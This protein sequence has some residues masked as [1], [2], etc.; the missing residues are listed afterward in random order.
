M[1]DFSQFVPAH[2]RSLGG[3]TPGKSARQAQR[4]SRVN[5][6]KMASNENPWGPSP[7]AVAAMQAVLSDCNFYPDNDAG[8]LRDALAK[9]HG[10]HRDQIVLT[11]GSTSLLGIIARTLLSPGLNA[12]TSERSF[13]VYPIATQAAGG[14]LIQVPMHRDTFDLDAL[15]AAVD[16]NTRIIYLSN[17]NNPTGTLVAAAELDHFLD[18]LPEHVVV[19]LD[20]AYYDFAHYFAVQRRVEYS[21][22]L[23]YANEGRRVVVLRTFSK[24]HGLAGV[25]VGYGIGPADLMSYFARVRTTFSVSAPAQAAALAALDDEA[26]VHRALVNNAEQAERLTESLRELGYEVVPTWANFL[27]CELGEDVAAVAKRLQ[28]EGVIIRPLGPWG[29]PTAIRIT[30]GTPEQNA[31]FLKAF[32]KVVERSLVK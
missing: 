21:R 28:A 30:I 3:Y 5:C 7:K 14:Q 20:E 13:I 6:I 23:Q 8:D 27:Y 10:V 24:A 17:P 16:G 2:I 11:A 12:V 22:S 15:A 32:R 19:I 1:T 9:R 31:V 26:H 4:E 29:A 25:R 18:K